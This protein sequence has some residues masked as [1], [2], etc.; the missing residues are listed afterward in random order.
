M[1]GTDRAEDNTWLRLNRRRT[2]TR[3]TVTPDRPIL[4]YSTASANQYNLIAETTE[5]EPTNQNPTR[6]PISRI[7]SINT[8]RNQQEDSPVQ[9][10]TLLLDPGA[11]EHIVGLVHEHSHPQI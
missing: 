2:G 9:P 3:S 6:L 8:T 7:P 11:A 4:Q 10:H 1:D 5:A